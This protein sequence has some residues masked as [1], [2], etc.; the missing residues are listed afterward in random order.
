MQKIRIEYIDFLKGYLLFC[1]CLSHFGYLPLIFKY[2]IVP[3]GSIYVPTFFLLSGVLNKRNNHFN[4]KDFIISKSKSL[5]IPFIFLFFVFIFLDWNLYLKP[6]ETLIQFRDA[7]IYAEGPPKASPLWFIIKLFEVN[8]IYYIILFFFK[9]TY[10]RAFVV[11]LCSI[12]GYLLFI[13]NVKL[14][15]GFE[16]ILSS[17]FFFGFGHLGK[18]YLNKILSSLNKKKWQYAFLMFLTLFC[19]SLILN[20]INKGVLGQNKINNYFLFYLAAIFGAVSFIMIS[21]LICEKF[22]SNFYFNRMLSFFKYLSLNALPILG[23]HVFIIIVVDQIQTKI[24]YI[25]PFDGFIIKIFSIL[26]LTYYFIVPFLYNKFYFIFGKENPNNTF[27][28]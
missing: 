23:T 1:I 2:L 3:T 28:K 17:I 11:F 12:L 25:S 19:I 24:K 4:F 10:I 22:K 14:P 5:L 15:L 18:N 20:N 27:S 8:L 9:N 16:V 7:L 26:F 6:F 21:N 13:F